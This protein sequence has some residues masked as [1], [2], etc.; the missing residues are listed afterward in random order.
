MSDCASRV[1]D[2]DR[3]VSVIVWVSDCDSGVSDCDSGVSVIVR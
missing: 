1:N 3:R 2:S